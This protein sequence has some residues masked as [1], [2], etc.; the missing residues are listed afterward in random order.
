MFGGP[1]L[2][3]LPYRVIRVVGFGGIKPM[4]VKAINTGQ[5]PN[6]VSMLGQ[7]RIRFL[8]GYNRPTLCGEGR[9]GHLDPV[10]LFFYPLSSQNGAELFFV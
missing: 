9:V 1:L 4:T 7:G 6:S 8:G 10:F 3:T 5:S 2:P